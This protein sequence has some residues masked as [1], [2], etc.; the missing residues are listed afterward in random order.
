VAEVDAKESVRL[1]LKLVE[2]L[3]VEDVQLRPSFGSVDYILAQVIGLD[4][5]ASSFQDLSLIA[6]ATARLDNSLI[7]FETR[8]NQIHKS[9]ME[10]GS[11]ACTLIP[12]D[13][14]L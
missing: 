7:F 13:A 5:V 10:I 12:E 9:L 3:A 4:A 2:V 11:G 14:L 6:K 8:D 1:F